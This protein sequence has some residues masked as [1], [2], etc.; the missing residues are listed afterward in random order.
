MDEPG[1]EVLLQTPGHNAVTSVNARTDADLGTYWTSDP[2]R[3]VGG[4]RNQV[5]WNGSLYPLGPPGS[6]M[7]EK[8]TVA[9][10]EAAVGYPVPV[11]ST[12]AASRANLTGVWVAPDS[13]RQAALVF[14]NGKVRIMMSPASCQCALKNF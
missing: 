6:G 10:A 14:D 13:G 1:L 5:G 9:G 12:A 7:A 3:Y 11:P 8:T 4:V 2:A